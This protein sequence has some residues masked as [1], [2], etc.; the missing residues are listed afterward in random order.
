MKGAAAPLRS[1]S[2]PTPET[3]AAEWAS[4]LS[5][6]ALPAAVTERAKR[7]LLDWVAVAIAGERSEVG[8]F[9]RSWLEHRDGPCTVLGAPGSVDA[10]TAAFAN[11]MLGHALDFDDNSRS[12]IGHLSTVVGPA[13]LAG[14]ELRTEEDRELSS[15][16]VVSGFVAGI[17]I[18]AWIGRAVNPEAF[19]AGVFTTAALGAV[20]AAAGASR[21]LGLGPDEAR[22]ALAIAAGAAGGTRANNGTPAKPYHAGSAARSGL[23]A[24][25]AA[26]LGLTAAADALS[27]PIGLVGHLGGDRSTLRA[28]AGRIGVDFELLDPGLE[29]KVHPCCSAAAAAVDAAI[30]LRARVGSAPR[31]VAAVRCR[32][33]EQVLD[34]LPFARP[35]TWREAQFSLPFCV[36]YA[37]AHGR[38]GLDALDDGVLGDPEVVRLQ[39]AVE[40]ELAPAHLRLGPEGAQVEVVLSDGRSLEETWPAGRGAPELPLAEPELLAKVHDCCAPSLDDEAIDGIVDAVRLLERGT[41]VELARALR[42]R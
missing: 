13:V 30:A 20:G 37:L 8:A 34:S 27:G 3:R 15:E 23:E 17:E 22:H 11:G 40:V 29:V 14:A 28:D 1:E 4:S 38:L 25:L 9:L 42:R 5:V 21:A 41:V 31:D 6:R 39:E 7:A 24:A 12:A 10:P 2:S 36:A 16:V 32:V 19:R 18:A 33:T 26:R 35:R